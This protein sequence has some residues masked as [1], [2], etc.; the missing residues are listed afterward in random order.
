M[1]NLTG[2][3]LIWRNSLKY[4]AFSRAT[5]MRWTKNGRIPTYDAHYR[6]GSP[7]SEVEKL[8]KGGDRVYWRSY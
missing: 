1:K 5:M 8:L 2:S 4:W 7:Y 3:K 6:R